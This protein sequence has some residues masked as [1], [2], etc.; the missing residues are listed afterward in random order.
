MDL[1]RFADLY[2]SETQEHLRLLN[3]G[4]LAME[5]GEAGGTDEA[6][7]AAHTIKGLSAAMGYPRVTELAHALEDRLAAVRGGGRLVDAAAVDALL[8]SAD[9]LEHAIEAAIAAGPSVPEPFSDVDQV[10]STLDD[11]A[12]PMPEARTGERIV[13][14]RLAPDAPIKAARALL[15]V[16]S[17]E[18]SDALLAYEPA[19]FDDDFD[20]VLTLVLGPGINEQDVETAIRAAG[21]VASVEWSPNER[22]APSDPTS[23]AAGPTLE[24]APAP[25]LAQLR[26][27][28]RRLDDLAEGI[29]EA[30]VLYARLNDAVEQDSA[31]A[32]MVDRLGTLLS[33]LQRTILSLRMVPVREVFDRFPRLVRDAA[34]ALDRHIDFRVEGGDIE[35]DRTILDEMMDPLVHLLRNAVGHGIELPGAREAAGKNP[36]GQIEIDARRVKD[37]IRISIRDDGA[38]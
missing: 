15:V 1:R 17:L 24:P 14:V 11:G 18:R 38:G 36:V 29:G 10:A 13:R 26:V 27:E 7:R 6:F 9:A 30:S 2:A 32:G 22:A 31:V 23:P 19:E 3:R 28:A 12:A 35:L 4:I 16:R 34:R 5:S 37:S 21:D 33:E 8:S 25:R 20:G